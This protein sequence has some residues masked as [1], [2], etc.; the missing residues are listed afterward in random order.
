MTRDI[1][2]GLRQ[3]M[4]AQGRS[5]AELAIVLDMPDQAAGK[6]HN[7][8]KALTLNELGDVA[9][10]LGLNPYA[11][12]GIAHAAPSPT[13]LAAVRAQAQFFKLRDAIALNPNGITHAAQLIQAQKELIE[14]MELEAAALC[15]ALAIAK[16]LPPMTA[17]EA[18]T[19]NRIE[20]N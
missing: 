3:H 1:A 19:L 4:D 12:I 7:G 17:A 11:F 8:K 5:L 2:A 9:A 18:K 14:C 6:R 20:G 16:A 15:D 13:E 10:W